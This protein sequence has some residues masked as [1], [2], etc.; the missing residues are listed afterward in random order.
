MNITFDQIKELLHIR[1]K[2]IE[3]DYDD[4]SFAIVGKEG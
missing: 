1:A 2:G 3:F 4:L